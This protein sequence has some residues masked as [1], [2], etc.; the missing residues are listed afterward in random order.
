MRLKWPVQPVWHLLSSTRECPTRGIHISFL[1]RSSR[2][3]CVDWVPA[4]GRHSRCL[5]AIGVPL[6]GQHR[7]DRLDPVAQP[8]DRNPLGAD[9]NEIHEI[10]WG[11]SSI[12]AKKP[13]ATLRISLAHCSSQSSAR[14][15]PTSADF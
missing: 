4:R 13:A 8:V 3:V 5:G 6:I 11:R 1:S 12:D 10:L 14:N 7:T 2:S 15:L 9:G